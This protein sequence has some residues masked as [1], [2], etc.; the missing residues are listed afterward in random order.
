MGARSDARRMCRQLMRKDP[1]LTV[2]EA[3]QA[4]P[5][6]PDFMSRL[7]EGLEIAGLPRN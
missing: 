3:R 1:D 7:A 2:A 5:F 6:T 4:W